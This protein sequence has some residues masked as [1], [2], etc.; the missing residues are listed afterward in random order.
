MRFPQSLPCSIIPPKSATHS[1]HTVPPAPLPP[2]GVKGQVVKI[3]SPYP[4]LSF[5][6]MLEWIPVFFLIFM[7]TVDPNKRN[8]HPLRLR[9]HLIFQKNGSL[10]HLFLG[11][12]RKHNQNTVRCSDLPCGGRHIDSRINR[13]RTTTVLTFFTAFFTA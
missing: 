13:Q 12:P 9:N 10:I 1:T 11:R 4:R 3:C 8:K 5:L 6:T 7:T 2:R